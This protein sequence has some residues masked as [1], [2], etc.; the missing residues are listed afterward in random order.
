MD[1]GAKHIFCN[2]SI[3]QVH[4][5]FSPPVKYMTVIA[6]QHRK[7]SV[8]ERSINDEHTMYSADFLSIG[9]QHTKTNQCSNGHIVLSQRSEYIHHRFFAQQ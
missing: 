8:S 3:I 9:I 4:I 2:N 6:R 1:I 7:Q 5:S